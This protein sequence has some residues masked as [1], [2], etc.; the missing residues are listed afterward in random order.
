[1][2]NTLRK[3]PPGQQNE[4]SGRTSNSE[5]ATITDVNVAGG[6]P[7]STSMQNGDEKERPKVARRQ[8]GNDGRRELTEDDAPEELGFAFPSW[9][10]WWIITVHSPSSSTRH[11]RNTN[12]PS[13]G[14]L[15]RPSLHELQRLHL[16]QRRLGH[17]ERI[18]HLRAS[19]ARRPV[20][21][22]HH[23]RLW[24]RTLGTLE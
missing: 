8:T 1:M 5:D 3:A 21:L 20:R 4:F 17:D 6:S 14:H 16:R 18:P 13:A 23:L 11:I 19:R 22:P 2:R 10:K 9:K 12:T 7:D 24:L 15:H